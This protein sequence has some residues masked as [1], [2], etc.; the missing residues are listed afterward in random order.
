MGYTQGSRAGT[1][2]SERSL[3]TA[4]VELSSP[5]RGR[6]VRLLRIELRAMDDL[7]SLGFDEPVD[8]DTMVVNGP[9]VTTGDD[10]TSRF[11]YTATVERTH[12]KAYEER[13]PSA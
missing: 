10:R 13:I 3:L 5:D 1:A 12:G 2:P 6:A 9:T 4:V 7:R 8:W 11:V